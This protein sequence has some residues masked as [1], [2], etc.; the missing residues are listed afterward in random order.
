VGSL[1]N[2]GDPKKKEYKPNNQ[3]ANLSSV[4]IKFLG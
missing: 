1:I 3:I 2:R 4:K